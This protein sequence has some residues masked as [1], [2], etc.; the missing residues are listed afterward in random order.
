MKI[1][2]LG[3]KNRWSYSKKVSKFINYSSKKNKEM[4]ENEKFLNE[5]IF[6][7]KKSEEEIAS[8]K[9]REAEEVFKEWEEKYGI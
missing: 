6:R 2:I 1:T 7:I 5:L 3:I 9:G 8:G 4:M